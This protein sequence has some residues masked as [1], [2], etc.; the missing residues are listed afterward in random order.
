MVTTDD[1]E[2]GLDE[3]C[4]QV[5][6]R[7]VDLQESVCRLRTDLTTGLDR[8]EARLDRMEFLLKAILILTMIT[9]GLT[10]V[11]LIVLIVRS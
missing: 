8:M 3:A 9:L 11:N 2:S 10:W 5:G 7:A 6:C 4:G 1:R